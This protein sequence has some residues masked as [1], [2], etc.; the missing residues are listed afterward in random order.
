MAETPHSQ[1]KDVGSIPGWGT[2]MPHATQ[3][4]LKK[5]KKKK[6]IKISFTFFCLLCKIQLVEVLDLHTW[7]CYIFIGSAATEQPSTNYCLKAKSAHS[8][9][10]VHKLW[11]FTFLNG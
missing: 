10:T 2:K 11:P 9:S 4:G 7:L 6:G 8:S 1:C 5:K 3:C